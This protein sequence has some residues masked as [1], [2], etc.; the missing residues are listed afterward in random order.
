MKNTLNVL[1][2]F[3]I[4]MV[5]I[6]TSSFIPQV[7]EEGASNPATSGELYNTILDLDQRF[8]EAYNTCDMETQ[9][10]LLA[11]TL[12]FYHDQGGL[13]TSK[14]DILKG[15]KENICGK[16]TRTLVPGSLEVSPIPGYGAAA[17]GLHKFKNKAEPEGTLSKESRFVTIWKKTNNQWQMTRIISL[18]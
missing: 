8:F 10:E 11:D 18:H 14:E 5:V 15:T 4:G 3:L 12:E 6:L 7:P 9:A 16:V 17:V 13:S 1:V 2:A